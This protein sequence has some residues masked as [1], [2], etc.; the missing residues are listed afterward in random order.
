MHDWEAWKIGDNRYRLPCGYEGGKIAC[1]NKMISDG[2]GGVNLNG[3][4]RQRKL[5]L[6]ESANKGLP[7]SPEHRAKLSAS[8]KAFVRKVGPRKASEESRQ[9]MSTSRRALLEKNP[10][11][12]PNRLLAGN[13]QKMTYPER[14]A[15]EWF[16]A[17][18]IAAR[19]NE[20]VGRFYPDFLVGNQ[21]VEI[22]GAR[23]HGSAKQQEKD[24]KRDEVLLQLGYRVCRI[25]ASSKIEE[26]LEKM[27]QQGLFQ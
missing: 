26:Q 23:W 8:L 4:N 5:G 10:E 3:F 11:L 7:V 16:E 14:V 2:V 6:R 19:H 24:R 25:P 22:D 27:K 20:R 9:R 13:K 1:R 21:I 18:G 17:Q 12:H 15:M